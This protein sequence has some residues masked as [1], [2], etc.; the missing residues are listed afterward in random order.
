MPKPTD[1]YRQWGRHAAHVAGWLL[2]YVIADRAALTH[3]PSGVALAPWNAA[4]AISFGMIARLG[5]R[6]FPAAL[7]APILAA[8]SGD[9]VSS[10]TAGRALSETLACGGAARALRGGA[11]ERPDFGRVRMA[12]RFFGTALAAAA[13]IGAARAA[14]VADLEPWGAVSLGGQVSLAHLVAI[15]AVAPLVATLGPP[16]RWAGGRFAISVEGL[17]QVTAL[18]VLAWEVFG[19]FANQ[20]IHFFYLLFLPLAWIATRNG[21]RGTAMALAALYLAPIWSDRQ[22]GHLDQSV[23]E[24]QIRLGVLA[25]TGLLLGAMVSERAE[26]EARGLARQTELAHFQR[27]NVGWE[28]A[29][30]LAHELNQP[31]TAAMNYTQAA[32]RLIRAPTPDLERAATLT[33]R[34]VDQIER[35]A[36]IIHGLRD[37]MRK[38]ELRLAPNEVRD[39]VED[40]LRLVSAEAN[41]AGVTL[42]AVGMAG[43]PPVMADKTQIVQVMVNL[44]RNAV[45]ALAGAKVNNPAVL[46]SA[47]AVEG[48]VEVM[49]TDN[50]PGLDPRVETRLFDPFVTTKEAGMG[51]GLSISKSILEAHDS[52]LWAESPPHGGV[53]F[54][55]TLPLARD[56]ADA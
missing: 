2:L 50:G 12:F 29:S 5:P 46:V 55:F 40:A 34:S 51:L 31:L 32:L 6:W 43:V 21:Q 36:Q 54:R 53:V 15:L 17:F 26:A 14:M 20:E 1:P 41:A 25:M 3:V 39:I 52:R 13:L 27:L 23:I 37:F 10:E 28:M 38:G 11:G 19:R 7:I 16:R 35:V 8:L 45:Q 4:P 56:L 18:M 47:R 33:A 44:V 22:F 9:G 30:A 42:H 49:V 48:A 24:L